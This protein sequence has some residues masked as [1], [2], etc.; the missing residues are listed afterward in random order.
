MFLCSSYSSKQS[1]YAYFRS[2]PH[3]QRPP[4]PSKVKDE[5]FVMYCLGCSFA[6]VDVVVKYG[7]EVDSQEDEDSLNLQLNIALIGLCSS[8]ARCALH[9]CAICA[10]MQLKHCCPPTL[11]AVRAC[12]DSMRF[13]ILGGCQFIVC[14]AALMCVAIAFYQWNSSS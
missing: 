14:S 8:L 6:V 3:R 11:H 2:K 7:L 13:S 10:G 9:S 12:D 1:G 5:W 4:N